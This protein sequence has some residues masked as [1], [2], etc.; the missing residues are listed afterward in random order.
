MSSPNSPLLQLTDQ[1]KKKL[2]KLL[3]GNE[4]LRIRD[5]IK[6]REEDPKYVTLFDKL[7]FTFGNYVFDNLFSKTSSLFF[8]R[9][10]VEH[11]CKPILLL[12]QA[13]VLLDLV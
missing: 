10:Y 5:H 13:E 12:K 1:M 3:T 7:S 11:M 2:R 9:R 8:S 4:M 6:S